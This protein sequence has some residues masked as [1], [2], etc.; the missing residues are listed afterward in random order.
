MPSKIQ[1]TE[2]SWNPIRARHRHT[3]KIG[4][5]CTHKNDA[6][7][8][9]Y[10]ERTNL[11][12]G[13]GVA[14]KPGLAQDVA[15]FLDEKRLVVPLRLTAPRLIFP[16][17]MTDLFGE[18]VPDGWLDKVYAVMAACPHH[19]FQVLTK[20]T[21]RMRD[22]LSD[23][24]YPDC[25]PGAGPMYRADEV[26]RG[27]LQDETARSFGITDDTFRRLKHG[28]N[29]TIWPLE[30][31]WQGVSAGTQRDLEE[32]W[33]DLKNTPAA[34]RWISLEPLLER[35]DLTPIFQ[36]TPYY[37]APDWIVVG[38]ESGSKEDARPYYLEWAREIIEQCREAGVKVFHKQ[39]GRN[40]MEKGQR[41]R[42]RDQKGGDMSEWPEDLRVR[43]MPGA[44][45][46][47]EA[48]APDDQLAM[49]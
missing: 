26:L 12:R 24:R 20:R 7:K 39:I 1:W 32:A 17:S 10:A 4:W 8:F 49:F 33:D 29:G 27:Y 13:N 45:P 30:N 23:P 31:V 41:W 21:G 11:F 43:E 37:P 44:E 5:F 3:G 9:C 35:V 48:A 47:L 36:Q 16:C 19:Q 42:A 40:P 6:C 25:V 28:I 18:F 14:F 22:Y 34:L 2:E 15:V 38:G 46:E